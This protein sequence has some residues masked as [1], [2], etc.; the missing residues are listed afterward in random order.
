[1]PTGRLAG[2]GPTM[3]VPPS[4]SR[5]RSHT[6]VVKPAGTVIA[7]NPSR[8]R[9]DQPTGERPFTVGSR[10]AVSLRGGTLAVGYATASS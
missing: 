4:P 2:I 1:M 6:S 3:R 5:S 10:G 8:P 9:R 7:G